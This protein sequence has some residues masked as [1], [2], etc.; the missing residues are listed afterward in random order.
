[1]RKKTSY[2]EVKSVGEKKNLCYG[3]SGCPEYVIAHGLEEGSVAHKPDKE[4]R[5]SDTG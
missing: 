3:G 5:I 1:M 4:Y 2:D